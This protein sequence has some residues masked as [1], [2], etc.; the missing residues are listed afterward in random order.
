M[1]HGAPSFQHWVYGSFKEL[2]FARAFPPVCDANVAGA[3][4]L[5]CPCSRR[6]GMPSSRE[7]W[8]D[9]KM[10]RSE[11]ESEFKSTSAETAFRKWWTEKTEHDGLPPTERDAYL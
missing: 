6:N 4:H 10:A 3:W 7:F 8:R 5:R 2:D 1:T 11:F 9:V